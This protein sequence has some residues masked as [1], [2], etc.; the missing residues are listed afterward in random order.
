MTTIKDPF[1]HDEITC[2]DLVEASKI[3]LF[4]DFNKTKK[5]EASS[6]ECSRIPNLW[7]LPLI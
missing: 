2:E 1:Y 7:Q 4:L 3:P 6:S 5:D